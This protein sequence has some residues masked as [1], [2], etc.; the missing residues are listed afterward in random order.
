MKKTLKKV[1]AIILALL[2]LTSVASVAL[3]TTDIASGTAGEGVTWVLDSDGTLT[4]SGTG[5]IEVEWYNPPWETYNDSI[6][7]VVIEEGIKDVPGSI[8]NHA[9][10]CVSVKIPASAEKIHPLAFDS[11]DSLKEI[12]LDE[13]N[14]NYKIVD[15]VLFSKDGKTLVYFPNNLGITE[16]TVPETVET[17]ADNAFYTNICLK[18]LTV[19]DSVTTLG[20]DA[21]Q[22]SEIEE[23]VLGNGVTEIP[24]SCFGSIPAKAIVVPD[25]IKTIGYAAF[26]SCTNLETIVIGSDIE[27]IDKDIFMYTFALTAVH[28]NGTQEQWDAIEIEE[29]NA[30]LNEKEIHFVKQKEGLEPTCKEG[31]T[32]GLYCELC[33]MYL[34]GNK[35]PAI[36]DHVFVEGV[37]D[38]GAVCDHSEDGYVQTAETHQLKCGVCGVI[39]AAEAHKIEYYEDN[40]EGKCTAYCE[41]CGYIDVLTKDHNMTAYDFYNDEYC[42]NFC[43]NCGYADE[44]KNLVKHSFIDI[45]YPAT[46]TEAANTKHICENCGA[47]ENNYDTDNAIVFELY[48]DDYEWENSALLV[49][50]N[51]EPVNLI[52]N[53]SGKEYDTFAMPYDKNLSYVFKWINGGYNEYYGVEIYLPDSD[54]PVFE[55][56]DMSGYDMLQTVYT[57]N[58]ADYSAVDEALAEIP[59]YLEYYSAE[60]VANLVT[61]V[62]GVSRMLPKSKQNEV[63]AMATAIKTAVDGLVELSDPVPNGVIN[64]S[65]GNFVYINDDFY[66]EKP[67]YTYYN[68][69]TDDEEFYEYDG[70]YVIFE[71]QPKDEGEEDYVHSGI[72]T[73][74]GDTE[75]DLV[76]TFITGYYG[77]LGIYD[78]A[79]VTLNLFGANALAV[80]EDSYCAGIELE[81]DAKLHIKDSNG[82]LVAISG[83]DCAGIGSEEDENNGEIIIDGGKIFALS[84]SDGAG[85]GSGNEGDAG[86]ITI[87]SGKIW[88]E[89][90]SDDG[91][92]IGVGDGG[93]GGEIIINGGDIT[94]LSLDDDGAGIGGADNGYVDSITINGGK[95][96]AGSEDGAAIGGGQ[97]AESRGGKI[98]INDGHISA[99]KWHDD[100]EYLIGNGSKESEGESEDNFVQINGGYIDERNS[101][102]IYP[103]PKNEN[104]NKVEKTTVEIH[105]SLIGKEITV[106]LSDGT[107]YTVIA[108]GTEITIYLPEN[109]T[110]E[111]ANELITGYCDHACHQDG[112]AGFF[113]KIICFFSKLFGTNQFC[114]CGMAHY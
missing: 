1:L 2:M 43:N 60:S 16:Y 73:Y 14:P 38:C 68:D 78:D 29:E 90:M 108:E 106:E 56:N 17:I 46:E 45:D 104:G 54:T 64:M 30:D 75:I 83:H 36:K 21:F 111:N 32:A 40:G 71:T 109:A 22:Y 97:E 112:A 98:T 51:G 12:I 94:A 26:W 41:I 110:V 31:N 65:A 107:E 114:E 13:S 58:V 23:F 42:I 113:W 52:R 62:K 89:C 105:E 74:F 4:I 69:E 95:I 80:S 70:G 25:N 47:Y 28:Y 34:T 72:Y 20:Y 103:A 15:G 8:L 35:I 61:A 37:C 85:I 24:S 39:E 53:M 101:K 11:M 18:K 96:V 27:H 92:G 48:S 86:K 67:G 44:E 76:N 63:D 5:K 77:N 88:A 59:E 91:S 49:Y 66:S 87:N 7:N 79:N 93:K 81:E 82:S 102:G 57:I 10:K 3:A 50:V 33:D 9:D 19:S 99:S 6:L 84:I 100:D 55:E